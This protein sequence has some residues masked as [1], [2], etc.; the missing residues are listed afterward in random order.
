MLPTLTNLLYPITASCKKERVAMCNGRDGRNIV[1]A[2]RNRESSDYSVPEEVS[3]K[4][5]MDSHRCMVVKHV[6]H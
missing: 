5:D 3:L 4:L 6:Q 1:L 2:T